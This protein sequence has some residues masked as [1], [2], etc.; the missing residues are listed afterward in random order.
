MD[1][2]Y[3]DGGRA[4]AGYKGRAGDCVVRAIAITTQKPYQEVYD[5]INALALAGSAVKRFKLQKGPRS[6]QERIRT[7]KKTLPSTFLVGGSGLARNRTC[8]AKRLL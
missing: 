4:A 7:A 2:V 8:Q 1:F 6:V 3:N 5:A